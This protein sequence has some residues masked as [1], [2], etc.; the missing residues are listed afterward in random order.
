MPSRPPL[1][2]HSTQLNWT[3]LPRVRPT[4]AYELPEN[5]GRFWTMYGGLTPWGRAPLGDLAPRFLFIGKE[6]DLNVWGL[7]NIWDLIYSN[8][9][10]HTRIVRLP[11]PRLPLLKMRRKRCKTREILVLL[12]FEVEMSKVVRRSHYVNIICRYFLYKSSFTSLCNSKKTTS[13]RVE[14]LMYFHSRTVFPSF[15]PLH[16]L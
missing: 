16:V 4:V 3:T 1:F 15:S 13:H 6:Y 8:L 14:I 5:Q 2:L 12:V 11:H 7:M 10:I 9:N